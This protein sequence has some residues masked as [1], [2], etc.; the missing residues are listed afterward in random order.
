ML[1]LDPVSDK[2]SK[3]QLTT[4]NLK[5]QP[6]IAL[7]FK[8]DFIRNKYALDQRPDFMK[9]VAT[10]LPLINQ[11]DP[12]NP[13]TDSNQKEDTKKM[14]PPN[15]FLKQKQDEENS[16]ELSLDYSGRNFCT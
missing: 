14:P 9:A 3:N 7:L 6:S 1:Q 16:V 4:F 12:Q 8:D 15:G 5:Q 10:Y 13:V 2:T 11:M